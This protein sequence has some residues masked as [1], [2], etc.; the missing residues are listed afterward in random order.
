SSSSN[1]RVEIVTINTTLPATNYEEI[2]CD[3][4]NDSKEIVNLSSKE[5][6][7]SPAVK[8]KQ[9]V[10]FLDHPNFFPNT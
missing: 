3:D 5:V 8:I 1:L 6:L 4:L 10:N 9:P 2:L 7:E